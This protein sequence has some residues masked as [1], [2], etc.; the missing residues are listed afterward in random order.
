[1]WHSLT[2]GHGNTTPRGLVQRLMKEIDPD[3]C[4]LR[5]R[6][7]LR[8]RSYWSSCP[9]H[10]WHIDGFDKL[11]DFGFPIHGCVDGFS[12]KVLWLNVSRS[13]KDPSVV[14]RSYLDC[15]DENEGCPLIVQWV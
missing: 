5:K 9:N 7:R 3:G 6:R 2:M 13:N 12:R 15:V 1:M 11:K 4:E 14:L 10:T 8:R